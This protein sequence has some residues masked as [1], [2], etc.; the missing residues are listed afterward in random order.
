[1]DTSMTPN[2]NFLEATKKIK[3][4]LFEGPSKVSLV[5][6]YRLLYDFNFEN[7]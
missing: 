4:F 7:L 1:M 6:K 2:H 5:L 3:I